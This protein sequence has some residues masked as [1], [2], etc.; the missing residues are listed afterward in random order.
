MLLLVLVL[1]HWTRFSQQ[2]EDLELK[3]RLLDSWARNKA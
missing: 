1:V 3:Q 2:T